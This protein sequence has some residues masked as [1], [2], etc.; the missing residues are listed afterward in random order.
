MSATQL[1]EPGLTR[2]T[3]GAIDRAGVDHANLW[4]EITEHRRISEDVTEP[5]SQLRRAGVHFSLDDFGMSYSNLSYLRN[6]PVE[7]IKVDRSFVSGIA[8]T[9]VDW[10]IVR[11]I[12][13]IADSLDLSVIAEGVETA[14]QRDAL[15]SLGCQWGQGYLLSR[16]LS[17]D[18]AAA[19]VRHGSGDRPTL[20]P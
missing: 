1:A 20:N 15:V 13:A 8:N 10:S 5:V 9:E 14:A 6:F 16:P 17:A 19:L 11:A 2:Q 12:L 18:D 7:S 3:L 4:L